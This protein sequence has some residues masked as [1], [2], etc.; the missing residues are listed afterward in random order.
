MIY[1]CRNLQIGMEHFG[2][3]YYPTIFILFGTL[4]IYMVEIGVGKKLQR[5]LKE[6]I[7]KE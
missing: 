2:G 7:W 4:N 5:D 6:K 3:E 1:E